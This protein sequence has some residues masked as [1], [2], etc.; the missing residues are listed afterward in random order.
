MPP[1]QGGTFDP[2]RVTHSLLPREWWHAS[3]SRVWLP[4]AAEMA[5]LDRRATESGA[6]PERALIE[7][8]GRALAGRVRARWPEARVACLA[9]S[10]HNGADALV[11]ARTLCAWG[12]PV[13]LVSCGTRPPE[14]DVLAGWDL[15][16]SP[17]SALEAALSR[18]DVALDGILGTGVDSAPRAPQAAIIDTLN[19]SGVEVVAVDGPSGVDFTTGATPGAAVRA[20]LTVTF[21]WPKLGLLRFPARGLCGE[22]EAVE[23]GFPP[24]S[25]APRARLIT[26]AWAA[27][28]LGARPDDAHKGRA[29]YLTLVGGQPGMAGAA[30]LAARAAIRGGVGIVRVASAPE[31]REVIQTGVPSAVFVD[32]GDAEAVRA[33]VEWA[34]AV[35]IGPGLG[36]GRRRLVERV[37]DAVGPRPVVMDADALNAFA[38]D[39][40]GL[41]DALPARALITPHPGEM[42][43]LW[44]GGR[45]AVLADPPGVAR[46]AAA[47]LDRTVLLKGTPSWVAE[48]DGSLRATSV[49]TA[50]FATGG[51]GD[52]LTGLA[53]AYAAAGLGPADAATCALEVSGVAAAMAPAAVGH[54]ATDVPDRIPAARRALAGPSAPA[55]PG[56]IAALPA[57]RGTPDA[58]D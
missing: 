17:A 8:A 7:N 56:V 43:R 42:G 45:E 40:D 33:A 35:A 20:D 23:I 41:A 14:P 51:V 11:A 55:G 39:L 31:N 34:H 52:V 21:G 2:L 12:H 22:L 4:T 28:I 58:R 9:G 54:A 47:R 3:A 5:E 19:A 6:I 32:W 48:P 30:I 24:P 38:D 37:L 49:A 10:G 1:G 57:A 29:G 46:A 44:E 18:A 50:A 25:P 53:G 16:M 27:E 36:D 15:T 26:A 13:E